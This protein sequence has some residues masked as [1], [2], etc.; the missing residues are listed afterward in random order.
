MMESGEELSEELINEQDEL[1][2]SLTSLNC[3]DLDYQIGEIVSKLN[4]NTSKQIST[5]SGLFL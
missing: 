3:W 1:I 2:S 5:M 4:I